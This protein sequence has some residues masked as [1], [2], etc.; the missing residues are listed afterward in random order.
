MTI[1]K[2][3]QVEIVIP[4]KRKWYHYVRGQRYHWRIRALNG[5]IIQSGEPQHNLV[6]VR[7]GAN[8]FALATGLTVVEVTE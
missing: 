5:K 1:E 6:D 3:Y 8:R 2:P 7:D 4:N